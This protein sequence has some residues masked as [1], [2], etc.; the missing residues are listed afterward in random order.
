MLGKLERVENQDPSSG[1]CATYWRVAVYQ[2]ASSPP[3]CLLLTD[4][5]LARIRAR[6]RKNPEDCRIP[7]PPTP[8]LGW[9]LLLVAG[10][11]LVALGLWT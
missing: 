1:A 9:A 3:E 8:W 7:E 11:G 10:A 6:A 5:E 4:G 2:D